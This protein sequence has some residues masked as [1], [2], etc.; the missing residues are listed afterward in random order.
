MNKFDINTKPIAKKLVNEIVH[1]MKE[2]YFPGDTSKETWVK[3]WKSTYSL[4]CSQQFLDK[5]NIASI[6]IKKAYNEWIEQNKEES[7][8]KQTENYNEPNEEETVM[9]N[10]WN[11]FKEYTIIS[12]K[13]NGKINSSENLNA[14]QWLRN[15]ELLG[16]TVSTDLKTLPKKFKKLILYAIRHKFDG[17]SMIDTDLTPITGQQSISLDYLKDAFTKQERLF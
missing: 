17:I 1:T 6:E 16:F 10:T 4:L 5:I 14:Y 12:A 7:S 15:N 11:R 9:R 8:T 13:N 2:A 3:V